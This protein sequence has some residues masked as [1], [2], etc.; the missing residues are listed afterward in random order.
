MGVVVTK[1][2][3]VLIFMGVVTIIVGFGALVLG[4]FVASTNIE[5]GSSAIEGMAQ[6]GREPT[7]PSSFNI[8]IHDTN[9][10]RMINTSANTV[11]EVIQEAGIFVGS[12]DV[13]EP[14]MN[15]PLSP[16]LQIVIRRA[17]PLTISVDGRLIEVQSN[18]TNA[19]SV[20]AENGIVLGEK[21]FTRPGSETLLLSNSLIEVVRVTESFE[22]EDTPIPYET[23]WQPS[24]LIQ[25]DQ[26]GLLQHGVPGILRQ[27]IRVTY[28]N[29]VAVSRTPD[30]EWVEQE[31]VPEVM[32]YGTMIVTRILQTDQGAYEYWRVVRM[33]VTSYTAATS[34]KERDHPAYG[35]TASGVEAGTGVVAVDKSIVPFRSWVYVPGYGIGYAGDTGGGIIGRWIDLGY[36]EDALV[37]WSGYIDVYYLTPIPDPE[38]INYRLPDELP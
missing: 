11:R 9:Q 2:R 7:S 10:Q 6:P 19:L 25:L 34:G 32:G 36:D 33:R 18:Q 3:L 14:A 31:P 17:M 16:N 20:L 1:L 30:G 28:E 35:I 12:E 15:T 13:V 37:W 4:G 5:Q 23:V 24:E 21:D 29:G 8:I 22:Y 26:E 27:S 38:D